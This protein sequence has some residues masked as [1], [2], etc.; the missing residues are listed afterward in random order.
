MQG[1]VDELVKTGAP[2]KPTAQIETKM[3]KLLKGGL[4]R[5]LGKPEIR[6]P[7]FP[8]MAEIANRSYRDRTP[9]LAVRPPK[10]PR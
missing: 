4:K 1:F 10:P 9:K 7:T 6:H 5:Y 3:E 2:I 8:P